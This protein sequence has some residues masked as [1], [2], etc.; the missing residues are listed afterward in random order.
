MNTSP[1]GTSWHAIDGQS[2]GRITTKRCVP[3]TL[4]VILK[5]GVPRAACIRKA[6]LISDVMG[7]RLPPSTPMS[8]LA[9]SPRRPP[10][11]PSW[12]TLISTEPPSSTPLSVPAKAAMAKRP[13]YRLRA[14]ASGS[15]RIFPASRLFPE[16]LGD[17]NHEGLC[18]WI[19]RRVLP[20]NS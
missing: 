4:T 8:R 14:T 15:V 16:D 13:P 19:F 10:C 11:V 1:P 9:L 5:C 7:L 3:F 6:V 17:F 20:L 2:S 12:I 18:R